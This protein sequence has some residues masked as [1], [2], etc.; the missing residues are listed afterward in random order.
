[1]WSFVLACAEVDAGVGPVDVPDAGVPLVDEPHAATESA[2]AHTTGG[3]SGVD[4][5]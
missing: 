2:T 1:M 3:R 5:R 4:L